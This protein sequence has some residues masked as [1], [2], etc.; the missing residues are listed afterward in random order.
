ML[1]I[2][3]SWSPFHSCLVNECATGWWYMAWKY[4]L[5]L[6]LSR[7]PFISHVS[8]RWS[9]T[10]PVTYSLYW[11]IL[12]ISFK[13]LA[14]MTGIEA[15]AQRYPS[16]VDVGCKVVIDG[17]HRRSGNNQIRLLLGTF[18][19]DWSGIVVWNN[20]EMSGK[21]ASTLEWQSIIVIDTIDSGQYWTH[22]NG[23]SNC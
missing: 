9:E 13:S 6:A 19:L 21:K 10:W 2:F 4:L 8:S 16:H 12:Q 20:Q 15:G 11:F 23:C 3:M 17:H 22:A 18:W 1:F 7:L 5:S 14:L